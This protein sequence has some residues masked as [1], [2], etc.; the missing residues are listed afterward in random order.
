MEEAKPVRDTVFMI[1]DQER[2]FFDLPLTAN[3]H[4]D[5]PPDKE[6]FLVKINWEKTVSQSKAISEYGFFGNQNT[7]SRPK[8]DKWDF[9]IKRLKEIWNIRE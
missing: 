3:Y 7:V 1:D 5:F 4:K 2:L 8:V 6:E 9:T